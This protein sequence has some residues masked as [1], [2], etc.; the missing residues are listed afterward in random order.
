[1]SELIE[2][3]MLYDD[4][5][6]KTV[7]EL[8]CICKNKKIK[9][10]SK[11]KTK[12]VLIEFMITNLSTQPIFDKIPSSLS[13]PSPPSPPPSKKI[14]YS[15]TF[16]DA[17]ENHVGMQQI[18]NKLECGLMLSDL[19]R[20]KNKYSNKECELINLTKLCEDSKEEAYIL[21]IRNF[22][23]S[24]LESKLEGE[25]KDIHWDK[26]YYDIRRKRVLNKLARHNVCFDEKGQ[27]ADISNGRGTIVAF[28]DMPSLNMIKNDLEQTTNLK[29]ICEGNKYYDVSKCGIGY[30][31]DA[32]RRVVIALRIGESMSLAYKWFYK[33]SHVGDKF[34]VMINSGD[35]YV[36]SDKAVGY[37]WKRRSIYTLRHA[38][39]C[40]KYTK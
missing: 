18:G 34:S 33:S 8:R 23:D 38:A 16:G 40:E 17:G 22:I 30:H 10:Y 19:E 12:R 36:M 28:E 24:E 35:A 1:M 11:C 15:L 27:V 7:V 37:D 32:E 14:T 20:I 31:G 13:L 2:N 4:L 9:G 3:G 25:L 21:I 29:L 26:T 6:K 39:G 5:N